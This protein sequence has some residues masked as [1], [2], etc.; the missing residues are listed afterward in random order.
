M[1][2]K[3]TFTNVH[4]LCRKHFIDCLFVL[5]VVFEK[6]LENSAAF[7][8]AIV[9]EIRHV[10]LKLNL[11]KIKNSYQIRLRGQFPPCNNCII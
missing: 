6:Y 8:R 10:L 11:I 3:I 2:K 9:R 1:V 5:S 7:G 4:L